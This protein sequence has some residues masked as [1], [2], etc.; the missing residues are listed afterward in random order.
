MTLVMI[1]SLLAGLRISV[2]AATLTGTATGYTKASDVVYDTSGEYVK[3]WGARGEVCT[4]LT[5]YAQ[6]YYTGNYSYET[7]AANS[8]SSSSSSY[9]SSALYTALQSMVRAK[10]TTTTSYGGTRDMYKYTD[11]VNNNISYISSFY[12]ATRFDGAWDN[13]E[14]WNREHVW[15]NSKADDERIGMC[16]TMT[17]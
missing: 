4:F 5:S 11:C 15:P 12:S 10:Q 13:G 16:L 7:L 17:S 3:N 9:T 14:T 6:A 8:G 2:S 1:V